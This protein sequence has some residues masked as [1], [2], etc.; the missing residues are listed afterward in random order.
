MKK[1]IFACIVLGGSAALAS[2][3]DTVSAHGL[4]D[5]GVAKETACEGNCPI[6]LG[7]GGASESRAGIRGGEAPGGNRS[8]IFT[9]ESV[10][11]I[12][13]G[14]A[15]PAAP[16][17]G[18]PA[19]IGLADYFGTFM[20][21]RQ[22][23]LEYLA[24]TG[25]A[26]PFQGRMVG[27]AIHPIGTAG[28]RFDN[29]VRYSA[30]VNG[31]SA[32]ASWNIGELDNS[33]AGRAWGMT[34]GIQHGPLILR[35]AHQNRNVARLRRYDQVGINMEA[36]NYLIAANLKLGWGAAY[37]AYSASR[38]WVSSPLF[39]PD[40]PYSA[41]IASTPSTDSRDVLIGVAVPRGHTTL[42]ASYIHKN[43][44]DPANHD[45]QQFAVGAT[46]AVSRRLD[47][48][49]AYSHIRNMNG[50]AQGADNVSV[51]GRGISAINIGMRHAF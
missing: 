20:F 42:L 9:V 2:A 8:A 7:G 32:A 14:R 47:F 24:L 26:D 23:D 5:A 13:T 38:G 22:Y 31:I 15:G 33:R 11:P 4:I 49:A 36:K 45:A 17:L 39:N 27:N 16:A 6:W 51:Y 28:R 19:W 30:K 41:G 46:Y 44:R 12:D 1:P 35:V 34:I 18:G 50:D 29:S 43:D 3:Q 40:N 37:A 48:Y 21:S 10:V 25:A